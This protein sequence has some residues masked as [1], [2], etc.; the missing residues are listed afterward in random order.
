MTAAN[1][2]ILTFAST[3]GSTSSQWPSLAISYTP[4]PPTPPSVPTSLSQTSDT[5]TKQPILH[6]TFSDPDSAGGYVVYTLKDS[7]GAVLESGSGA[8]ATTG[9]DS[10]YVVGT[11]IQAGQTYTWTAYASDGDHSSPPTG[12]QTLDTSNAANININA[13]NYSKPWQALSIGTPAGD[14]SQDVTLN[15]MAPDGSNIQAILCN[16]HE[17][18]WRISGKWQVETR[19]GGFTCSVPVFHEQWSKTLKRHCILFVCWWS[20]TTVKYKEKPSAGYAKTVS[21]WDTTMPINS[22]GRYHIHLKDHAIAETG[23]FVTLVDID[24]VNFTCS[25]DTGCAYDS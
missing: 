14:G 20:D 23:A 3:E 19:M 4:Q 8:D 6:A 17:L 22:A 1:G 24:G 11:Q 25:A 21:V 16:I 12:V 7:S 9:S 2:N 5:E 13:G 15:A 18:S 10:A